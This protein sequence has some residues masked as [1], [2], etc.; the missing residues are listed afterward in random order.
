AQGGT[1]GLPGGLGTHGALTDHGPL[2]T[3]HYPSTNPLPALERWKLLDNLRRSLVP[4]G[5]LVLLVLGWTTLPGSPWLW[6]A[7][8]L[9]GFALPLFQMVL[10]IVIGCLRSRSLAP[11]RKLRV[12]IPAVIGQVLLEID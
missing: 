6:T 5:L 9:A 8:A 2:T 12:S 10:T 3:D 4:P 7:T 11:L 1:E